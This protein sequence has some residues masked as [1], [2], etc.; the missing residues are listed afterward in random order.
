[1]R[2]PRNGPRPPPAADIRRTRTR[3]LPGRCCARARGRLTR[4]MS[5][6]LKK[7]AQGLVASEEGVTQKDWGGRVRVALLYPNTHPVSMSNL[8]FPPIY[9]HLTPLPPL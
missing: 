8:R 2:G 4:A 5:W 1:M 9:D 7:K 6:K 3:A